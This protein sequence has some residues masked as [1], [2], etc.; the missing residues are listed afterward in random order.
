M[1]GL[2]AGNKRKSNNEKFELSKLKCTFDPSVNLSRNIYFSENFSEFL[3]VLDSEFLPVVF[4]SI[5]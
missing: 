4:F 2:F 3:Q 1:L 5:S